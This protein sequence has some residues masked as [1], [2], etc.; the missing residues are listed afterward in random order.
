MKNPLA[1]ILDHTQLSLWKMNKEDTHYKNFQVIEKE[2]KRC[3]TIIDNL[4]KF[5]RQEKV[6]VWPVKIRS[7]L[8]D[9][10]FTTKPTGK[11]TG[12]GISLSHSIIKDHGGDILI[13]SEYGK[14]STFVI[15]LPVICSEGAP[16]AHYEDLNHVKNTAERKRSD[17]GS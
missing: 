13:E 16:P 8:F 14:G 12:R 15:T 10:F 9:L 5:E 11:G 3:R 1:G 4:L 6:S 7:K 17:Q 2:T